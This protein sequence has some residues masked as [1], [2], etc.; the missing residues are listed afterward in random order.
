MG[1]SISST[2]T[3]S[4]GGLV[5]GIDT[6]SLTDS[7]V[8]LEQQKVTAITTQQQSSQ[9][10]LSDLGTVSSML[11]TFSTD[12][13]AI[14]TLADF[15]LFTPSSTNSAA[16]TIT[17]TGSGMQGNVNVAVQQLATSWE[18]AS[19]PQSSSIVG[20]NLSGT[21]NISQSAASQ[22]STGTS[23][24]LQVSIAS[25]DTLQNIAS[26]INATTGSGVTASVV[27]LGT[28]DTRLMLNGVDTGSTSF[29]V[30][31]SD[32]GNVLS[33]LGLQSSTTN[34]TSNFQLKQAA[35]GPATAT[36]TLGSLYTGIGANNVASGDSI[37]LSWTNGSKNGSL[38]G[39]ASDI[40]GGATSDM[41]QVTV[42]QLSSWM[43]SQMGGDA[44]VNV[45]SSGQLVATSAGGK[46]LSFTLGM[47]SGSTGTIPLGSSTSGN[48]WAN[49]LQQGQSAFYTMNGISVASSSNQ[50]STTV[51]GATINLVGVT[52]STNPPATL[53]LSLNTTGIQ[54]NIQTMLTD[55]NN[56]QDYISQK[57]TSSDK[58]STD[59]NGLTVNTVTPGELSSDTAVGML[60]QQLQTMMTMPIPA[61]A[62]KTQYNSLASVGITTD[63][64]TGHLTIDQ[65]TFQAALTA[66]PQGVARLF[67]NS[68][69]TDNGN[70]T[71]GGWTNSTQTGTYNLTPSTDTF[72]GSPGNRVG[73]I[74]FS[75]KGNSNGLGV[76][77]PTSLSGSLNAT[78]VRGIAGQIGQFINQV[79]DPVSGILTSDST[80][81]QTQITD[82]GKQASDEQTRV[83]DYRTQ[84]QASFTAMESAMSTLKNQSSSFLSAISGST[85]STSTTT[86]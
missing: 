57:T 23:T 29:S 15:S 72:D 5:S 25:T 7:L 38:S 80:S 67:S 44:K 10:A 11:S 31:E 51:T 14:S 68:A 46:A 26:K 58:Q 16:A 8:A 70:A 64:S 60:A 56:L 79:Q 13:S 76:T 1:T 84:L 28:G 48:N 71:V 77:A 33:G 39:T 17:G 63:A 4:V 69:W 2:G 18:V 24:P 65:T 53:S 82:L 73:D 40:S 19:S 35:G 50:D 3:I 20:L 47:G 78:F 32:S 85:S 30:T 83:D 37:T 55:Y 41:S 81:Y 62:G 75:T 49:V 45:N 12:A 54:T 66:D 22:L 27:T 21:L 6:N 52:S 9:L 43:S 42:S 36:T 74:L 34:A 86:G 61:L 59:A